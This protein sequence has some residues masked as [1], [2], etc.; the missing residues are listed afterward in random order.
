MRK[1]SKLLLLMPCASVFFI[2]CKEEKF[3][4]ARLLVANVVI[5]PPVS[6]SPIPTRGDSVD[7][8]WGGNLVLNNVVYGAASVTS[9]TPIVTTQ[10]NNPF[11][12]PSTSPLFNFPAIVI[13]ASYATVQSGAFP[14]N[15]SF[16]G[17]PGSTLYNRVTSFL[18]GRSY[19]AV[20]FDFNP[21]FKTVVMEDDLS[22]PPTGKAKVRFVHAIPSALF[23]TSPKRDTI[24]VTFTGGPVGS[25][26]ANV[27]QFP[28]RFFADSY[29]NANNIQ[30]AVV[31]TGRYTI[32]YRV[33]GTPGT[34]PTTGLLGSF[35]NIRLENRKIYTI[36]ARIHFPTI[37]TTPAGATFIT[38]N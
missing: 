16:A 2:S 34:L 23:S 36:V 30:F 33:S 20:A 38:H 25:P 37:A 12:V 1:L 28:R 8:R 11:G 6:P 9:G 29:T 27:N 21:F 26:V 19:T 5:K 17:S 10:V 14:L 3:D 32:N 15:L 31:D 22:A 18:P 35:P 24:D 7:V 4:P 13:P